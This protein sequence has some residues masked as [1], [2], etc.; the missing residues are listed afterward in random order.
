MLFFT[1][2][3]DYSNTPY[4]D[5]NLPDWS[6]VIVIYHITDVLTESYLTS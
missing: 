6:L 1:F 4:S 3:L 5:L 2:C